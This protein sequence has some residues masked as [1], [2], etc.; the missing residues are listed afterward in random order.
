MEQIDTDLYPN[1]LESMAWQSFLGPRPKD[2]EPPSERAPAEKKKSFFRRSFFRLS[3]PP[4]VRDHTGVSL[5]HT[6]DHIGGSTHKYFVKRALHLSPI[7][8]FEQHRAS[9]QPLKANTAAGP[10]FL[11]RLEALPSVERTHAHGNVVE[12]SRLR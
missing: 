11:K 2:R 12:L 10:L 3:L 1:P 5:L 4:Y 9:F 7:Q 6:M 8:R